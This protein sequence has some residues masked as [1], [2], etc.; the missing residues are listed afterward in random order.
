VRNWGKQHKPKTEYSVIVM[1]TNLM[2]YLSLIYFVSQP[3]HVSRMFIAHHQEGF[4]VYVQQLVRLIRLSWLAAGRIRMELHFHPDQPARAHA[5]HKPCP[6]N[7]ITGSSKSLLVW[8][9]LTG[10]WKHYHSAL[11]GY[12]AD[13]PLIVTTFHF[14]LDW[15]LR[16]LKLL[17]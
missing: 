13:L 10:C 9:I 14:F 17:L 7:R 6:V 16:K 4:T 12:K 8:L 1:K 15:P 11:W 2:H 3:L 5:V